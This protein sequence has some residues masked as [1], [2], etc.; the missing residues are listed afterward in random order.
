MILDGKKVNMKIYLKNEK[1][2]LFLSPKIILGIIMA[3]FHAKLI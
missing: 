1:I 2:K 3:F